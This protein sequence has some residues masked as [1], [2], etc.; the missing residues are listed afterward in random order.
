MNLIHDHQPIQRLHDNLRHLA[1]ASISLYRDDSDSY[2]VQIE[3]LNGYDS[4]IPSKAL[5]TNEI[6]PSGSQWQQ[7]LGWHS[8]VGIP[9][10]VDRD[11]FIT[12]GYESIIKHP[13]RGAYPIF[14]GLSFDFPFTPTLQEHLNNWYRQA[15][16]VSPH[17]SVNDANG[18]I[19]AKSTSAQAHQ[20][21]EAYIVAKALED[22][23]NKIPLL[24]RTV[25]LSESQMPDY[26]IKNANPIA[27]L[28]KTETLVATVAPIERHFSKG[29]KRQLDWFIQMNRT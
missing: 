29:M 2:S 28:K 3:P 21:I 9:F 12:I 27:S 17:E 7:S 24:F 5:V 4:G 8:Y 6:L 19:R 15:I 26:G 23:Q 1:R 18:L 13:T 11:R 14:G 20:S 16:L 10:T 25:I 22:Y